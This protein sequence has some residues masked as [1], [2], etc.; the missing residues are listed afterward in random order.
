MQRTNYN[1]DLKSTARLNSSTATANGPGNAMALKELSDV[2]PQRGSATTAL[3]PSKPH[4]RLDVAATLQAREVMLSSPRPQP[5]PT[6]T[7][8]PRCIGMARRKQIEMDP[9]LLTMTPVAAP[10]C[11]H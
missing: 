7:Y 9:S 2:H 6:P 4:S 5:S 1:R 8:T 10:R 3:E 11:L